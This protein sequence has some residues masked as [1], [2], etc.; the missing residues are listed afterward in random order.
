MKI[1]Y[2]FVFFTFLFQSQLAFAG[3]N[4][5]LRIATKTNNVES[6]KSL[7][8]KG[9]DI[10]STN[11]KG[12]TPLII[13][14]QFNALDAAKVL[15]EAGAN[16]NVQH[17]NGGT[18]LFF[19]AKNDS[20][21]VAQLLLANGANSTIKNTEGYTPYEIARENGSYL[22]EKLLLN[23]RRSVALMLDYEGKTISDDEF[24]NAAIAALSRRGWQIVEITTRQVNGVLE[25]SDFIY[26]CRIILTDKEIVIRYVTGYGVVKLN[27]LLNLEGDM[28][29]TLGL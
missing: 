13:A 5:D 14:A 16:L 4:K 12:K 19:A 2:S 11:K 29:K 9:A 28:R 24:K 20:V 18:P 6:V 26:K 27:Y 3:I 25:K 22:I 23:G 17:N 21:K 8:T 7:I 1:I 15:V 10:E